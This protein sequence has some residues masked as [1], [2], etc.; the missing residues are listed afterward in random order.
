MKKLRLACCFLLTMATVLVYGK[1]AE[2]ILK[3]E[4]ENHLT[5]MLEWVCSI[6]EYTN[7]EA[8]DRAKEH[9]FD[10]FYQVV[11]SDGQTTNE[12]KKF[13][14]LIE[15][16]ELPSHITEDI[17]ELTKLEEFRKELCELIS[18]R[19]GLNYKYFNHLKIQKDKIAGIIGANCSKWEELENNLKQ[20]YAGFMVAEE[21]DEW[22]TFLRKVKIPAYKEEA[23]QRRKQKEQQAEEAKQEFSKYKEIL[24]LNTYSDENVTKCVDFISSYPQSKYVEKVREKKKWLENLNSA[25]EPNKDQS[26]STPK[27]ELVNASTG[28]NEDSSQ[29]SE[30]QTETPVKGEQNT[31]GDTRA[32]ETEDTNG[33]VVSGKVEYDITKESHQRISK[34]NRESSTTSKSEVDKKAKNDNPYIWIALAVVVVV[35]ATG[36]LCVYLKKKKK[37]EVL[38]VPP[39]NGEADKG[40]HPKVPQSTQE[41]Q[42]SEAPKSEPSLNVDKKDQG[43]SEVD[44]TVVPVPIQGSWVLVGASVRGNGHIESNLPC[45]DNHK[46]EELE[47]GWGI[48]IVSD[49]AGSAAHSDMG[50]KIVVERGLF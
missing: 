8:L 3:Q 14:S 39:T 48:A 34:D 10:A 19:Q 2:Q 41:S 43:K 11:M 29:N 26:S 23:G 46:Y 25:P 6:M 35:S 7:Q 36:L 21:N 45:Q 31:E 49:G 28:Q 42:V 13:R 9:K 30:E 38:E 20:D 15:N 1:S 37:E 4:L 50:S 40:T 32:T 27:T 33:V 17:N 18:T 16:I 24:E 22:N 12:V 44:A 5:E 47:K